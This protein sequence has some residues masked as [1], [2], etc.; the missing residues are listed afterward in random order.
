MWNV[1][2]KERLDKIPKIYE[3]EK[4]NL[5]DKLIHLH[6]FIGGCDW[7]VSEFDGKDTFWGYAILNSD[8][9]LA[10]W[11]YFSFSEL[12]AISINGIEIDCEL[13]EYFKIRKASEIDK[14]CIGNRWNGHTAYDYSNEELKKI[15][16]QAATD[17]II[18]LRCS[19][20]GDTLRCEPDAKDSFCHSCRKVVPTN[21][22]LISMGLI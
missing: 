6:F 7:Y 18:E 16:R 20:C 13:E 17:S 2:T 1:P 11:G 12:Q 5:K 22:P 14:I 21:N 8:Y 19:D 4:L 3:T 9:D 15:V 10:E